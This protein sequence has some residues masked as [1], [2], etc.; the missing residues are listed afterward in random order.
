MWLNFI[1]IFHL[2]IQ[3]RQSIIAEN[4]RERKEVLKKGNIIS[5][6]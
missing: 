3:L 5:I 6:F 4:L 1:P 2:N